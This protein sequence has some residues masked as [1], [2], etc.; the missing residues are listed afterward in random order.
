MSPPSHKVSGT[1]DYLTV[2]LK[3]TLN[4]V[5]RIPPQVCWEYIAKIRQ[6]PLKEILVVRLQAQNNDESAAYTEFFSYLQTRRRFGV[7][8]NANKMVKDC[9]IMPLAKSDPIPEALLPLEGTGLPVNR[10]DL[11]L[12]SQ[13]Q[14]TSAKTC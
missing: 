13:L 8:G 5:G 1:T 2:D 14:G 6:N 9:Y 4:L 10:G 12:V 3:K 7:V 11:L